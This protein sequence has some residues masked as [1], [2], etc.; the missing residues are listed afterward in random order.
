MV[1]RPA[2]DTFP[3]TNVEVGELCSRKQ[4]LLVRAAGRRGVPRVELP[5]RESE[6][7]TETSKE[8]TDIIFIICVRHG[9]VKRIDQDHSLNT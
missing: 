5:S 6:R 8:E 9:E 1:V 2:E 3:P 4:P 7:L